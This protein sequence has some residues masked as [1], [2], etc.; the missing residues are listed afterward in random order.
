VPHAIELEISA[1]TASSILATIGGTSIIGNFVMG[2]ICDKIGPRFVFI[3]SFFLMSAA[4][5][6]LVWARELPG[7]YLF[8]VVFGFNHGGNATAQTPIVARLFGLSAVGSI[9]GAAS[10]GFT[11]GGATGPV[12]TGYLFDLTG[13][14]QL[15]FVMGAA[16]G[17][18]GLILTIILRPTGRLGVKI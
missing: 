17:L 1:L 6:W 11:L 5:F 3:I 12:V 14:Y 18:I 4:L 16:I 10:F 8:A 15:A 9:F 7:L 2:R 13:S